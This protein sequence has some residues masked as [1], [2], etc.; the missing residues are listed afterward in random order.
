MK[1]CLFLKVKTKNNCSQL[2]RVFSSTMA[3]LLFDTQQQGVRVVL[4]CVLQGNRHFELP[5][6]SEGTIVSLVVIRLCG[7]SSLTFIY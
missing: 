4:G 7:I 3:R 5:L 6:S 2:P 1:P